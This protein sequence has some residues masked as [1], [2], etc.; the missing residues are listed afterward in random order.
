MKEEIVYQNKWLIDRI[1]QV[2]D[3]IRSKVTYQIDFESRCIKRVAEYLA[4]SDSN[5]KNRQYIEKM[6]NEVAS[7]VIKRN[8]NEHYSCFNELSYQDEDNSE[9]EFD[10]EDVLAD[11]EAEL[12]NKETINLL[13]EGDRQK[14]VILEAWSLG[15][16]NNSLISRTLA[17][18]LG[19]KPESYRKSINRFK[20]SCADRITYLSA[21]I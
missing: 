7:S 14:K 3:K 13:A 11:V 21:A 8:K 6:I 5:I 12:I 18:V 15:N 17:D 20:K 9:I 10:P 2:S 1:Y 4:L 19:G 16:T